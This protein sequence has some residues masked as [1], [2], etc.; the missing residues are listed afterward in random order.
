MADS[1]RRSPYPVVALVGTMIAFVI[2]V[3]GFALA[4]P[5]SVLDH[6]YRSLQLFVLEAGDGFPTPALWQLEFARLAAPAMTV[7]TTALAAAALSRHR[8]DAWRARRRRGHVVVAGLD[9]RGARAALVLK[10]AGLDVVG[11]EAD[12][13]SDGVRR[14]RQAGVPVVIGSPDQPLVLASAG[15][16]RAEHLIVLTPDLEASG[17]IAMA[18][19]G[20]CARRG[21]P[22]L[23]VHVELD[24]PEL[25]GL[26]RALK[27]SEHHAPGWRIEELDLARAGAARLVDAIEPWSDTAADAE[28][29]VLGRSAL[30]AAVAT[31]LRR[32]WRAGGHQQHDLVLSRDRGL[33]APSGSGAIS[34]AFVCLEDET[35]ALT[36]ALALVRELPEV[37]VV[38]HLEHAVEFAG[39][40]ER[41]SPTLHVVGLD[42]QVLTAEVLLDTTVERIARA[43]HESYRRHTDPGDASA[44]PWADLPD[45]L[46]ASNRSQ[47]THVADKIRATGR[48]LVP[49][50]GTPPDEFSEDEVQLLGRLEHDRWM[51]ERRA[52]GWTAGPRDAAARTSPYLVSWEE[53]TEDIR[54]I[55]R[56]FVRALPGVLADAG[57][58]LRRIPT[59]SWDPTLADVRHGS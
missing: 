24:D 36:T 47:A 46:K 6:A 5:G 23:V 18:A 42:Q 9:R 12:P 28:V 53:L 16:A 31:E 37:P 49:D 13:S 22:P 17:R 3:W 29:L 33:A 14:T 25:A 4:G 8:V 54:E 39:L 15:L 21:E 35:R 43:L 57:L 59:R 7:L 48:L 27:L 19:V 1:E 45:S 55:D 11:V 30:A 10:A 20:L 56:Q 44:V 32:R 58:V 41:D 34:A 40:L 51:A 38:V 2:G 52:A 26:L 50:D